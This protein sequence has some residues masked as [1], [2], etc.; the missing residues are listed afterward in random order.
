MNTQAS[1][2]VRARQLRHLDGDHGRISVRPDRYRRTSGAFGRTADAAFRDG[3]GD[4]P[5]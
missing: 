4:E 1:N 3:E 2:D 5:D